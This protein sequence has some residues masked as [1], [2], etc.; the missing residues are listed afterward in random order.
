MPKVD[1]QSSRRLFFAVA[2]IYAA[3][4]GAQEVAEIPFF[5]A[6]PGTAALGGGIRGGQNP[7]FANNNEDL[8]TKDLVPLYLYEGKYLYAHGTAGGVHV[9]RNDAFQANVYMRYRFQKLDPGSNPFYEGLEERKQSLDAGLQFSLTQKW[10]QVS[11]MAVHDTLNRHQG[12]EVQTSYRFFIDAGSWSLSPY[13]SWTWQD[14][15]LSEYY[16]GVSEEEARPDRPAYSPGDS[17]WLGFGI[18]TAWHISDKI[19]L[20]ANVGFAGADSG[21]ENSPLVE[22]PNF[23]SLFVGG[24]YVFGNVLEPT[25]VLDEERV[26]EWSWRVN[27]GYQADGNIVSEIDQGDFSKSTFA[28]TNIGGFT[29]GKLLSA[30]PRVDFL[31]RVAAFRHFEEDEGNSNFWSYAAYIMAMG[32]GYSPWSKQEW[33]RWGFGFGMSYA[34]KVPIAEQRKQASKGENTS[35]FL[36]YLEMTLDFPLWRVSKADWLKNCYAGLTIVHRSGIF[37]TSDLL[38]DLGGGADWLTAH[39]ECKR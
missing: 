5:Y 19:V 32:K 25:Y 20:F 6:E 22:E 29:L 13:V 3:Q 33:F 9:F 17:Q 8:R 23:S 39:L 30:G 26:G 18:N 15:N 38:G 12:S 2:C 21:I 10:G 28:D 35:H 11:L 37:G 1:I 27:Y 14:D 31:G 36:N 34:E 7:Y 4:L 24:T 16:F